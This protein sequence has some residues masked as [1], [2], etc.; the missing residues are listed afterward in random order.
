MLQSSSNAKESTIQ[1]RISKEQK[2]ILS[3]V[4]NLQHK[5]LSSFVLM[6]AY[7]AAQQ[8]LAAQILKL[9]PEEWYLFCEALDQPARSIPKLQSL[10]QSPGL[11]D[12]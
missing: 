2:C 5:T 12:D 8:I 10:L 11:L 1:L 4:A 9:S 3:K 6:S 7:E